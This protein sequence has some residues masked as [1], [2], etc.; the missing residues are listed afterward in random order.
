[1][2]TLTAQPHCCILSNVVLIKHISMFAFN[3]TFQKQLLAASMPAVPIASISVIA[4][5]IA[6]LSLA[7]RVTDGSGQSSR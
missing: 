3:F 5:V 2:V 7:K 4:A 1:M 6:L